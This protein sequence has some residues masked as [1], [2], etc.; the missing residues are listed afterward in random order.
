LETG[1]QLI[2]D[3][4]DFKSAFDKINSGINERINSTTSPDIPENE[5]NNENE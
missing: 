3:F 5:K 2:G 4:M 1:A